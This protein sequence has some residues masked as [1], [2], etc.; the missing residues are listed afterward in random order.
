MLTLENVSKTFLPGTVNER[1][2]LRDVSLHMEAGEFATVI[3]SNGA[4]KSTLFAAIS[5]T[6]LPDAGRVLLDGSEITFQPEHKRARDIG[7]LF[8]D[9]AKGTAPNL[10]IEENLSLAYG[11]SKRGGLSPAVSKRDRAMFRE[12]LRAFGM[13]LEDR[14]QT[15][16]GT[17]SGGQ[18]QAMTLLM[19]TIGKPKL[20]LLDEHTAALDPATAEKVLQITLDVV[21]EQS[22][23]TLMI[24]H[25]MRSALALGSRTLMMDEGRILLDVQG[26]ERAQMTVDDLLALYHLKR[27]ENLA[28]DRMLMS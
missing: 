14:M 9:P 17:L 20:L 28:N 16:V 10:T 25:N 12:R 24:T 13:G 22:L 5:G 27:G 2:A 19:A 1:A 18:R 7:V 4:G 23:T 6:F 15:K 3:G 21:R 26:E 8:Q 11:H